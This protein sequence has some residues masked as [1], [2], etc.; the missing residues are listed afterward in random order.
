MS[1]NK[2][3][4]NL[5]EYLKIKTVH[6]NPDYGIFIWKIFFLIYVFFYKENAIKFIRK[7]AEDIGFDYFKEVEVNKSLKII[8]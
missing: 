1:D 3:V 2:A 7:C 8:S 4:E 6:P 5:I